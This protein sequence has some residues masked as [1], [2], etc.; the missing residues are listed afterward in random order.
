MGLKRFWRQNFSLFL[1]KLKKLGFTA[2]L[3]PCGTLRFYLLQSA[4]KTTVNRY[5]VK[6][7]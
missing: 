5:F 3:T 4:I 2:T 6:S 1:V 7:V